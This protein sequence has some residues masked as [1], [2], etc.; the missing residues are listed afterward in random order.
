MVGH[1]EPTATTLDLGEYTDILDALHTGQNTSGNNSEYV[2]L[3]DLKQYVS[4]N[5]QSTKALHLNIRSLPDNFDKLNI[6][7]QKLNDDGITLDF[8]LLCESYL[9]NMNSNLYNIPGYKFVC[10][11]RTYAKRGGVGIYVR[12][13]I[14]F[15]MKE[16]ISLFE[17]SKFESIF[18]EAETKDK[19][20]IV[21][22]I[23]RIPNTSELESIE[24][25]DTVINR[26]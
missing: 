20:T 19:S 6:F 8:I 4:G 18:I 22:E 12:D 13:T 9:T 3:S 10:K 26:I 23:Y 24:Y 21:G 1:S 25:F 15:S 7:L 17:E 16:D 5:L 2:E 14:K 11:N